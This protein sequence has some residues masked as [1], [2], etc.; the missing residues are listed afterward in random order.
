MISAISYYSLNGIRNRWRWLKNEFFEYIYLHVRYVDERERERE[1]LNANRTISSPQTSG[2]Q[3]NTD[4][5]HENADQLPINHQTASFHSRINHQ[6][7]STQPISSTQS[8]STQPL[9]TIQSTL[10]QSISNIPSSS[11]LTRQRNYRR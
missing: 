11:M 7:S 6:S 1:F 2:V 3:A 4:S 9:Q 5:S 10:S 8:T